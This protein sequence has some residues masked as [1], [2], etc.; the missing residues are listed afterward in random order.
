M[1]SIPEPQVIALPPIELQDTKHDFEQDM[2]DRKDSHMA[3]RIS[4]T[5]EYNKGSRFQEEGDSLLNNR[6][7]DD[8]E[9][10]T[11]RPSVLRSKKFL[12]ISLTIAAI[13]IIAAIA[14]VVW[15]EKDAD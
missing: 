1:V 9:P 3:I 11:E 6:V 4:A 5:P 12:I 15:V 13:L 14:L 10:S 7:D 8:T 2:T